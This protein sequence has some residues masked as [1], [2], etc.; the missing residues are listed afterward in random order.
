[1]LSIDPEK[2]DDGKLAKATK[3]RLVSCRLL[4]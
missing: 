1:M 2:K 4:V 3:D